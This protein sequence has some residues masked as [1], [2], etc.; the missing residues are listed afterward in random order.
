MGLN[1]GFFCEIRRPAAGTMTR[2]KS[3]CIFQLDYCNQ[4]TTDV[5]YKKHG[6]ALSIFCMSQIL[7]EAG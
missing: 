5:R 3:I 4:W 2:F 7:F 1:S 6:D